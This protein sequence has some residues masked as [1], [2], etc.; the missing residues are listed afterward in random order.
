[1]NK[2]NKSDNKINEV[3]FTSRVE[4]VKKLV[5]YMT[6]VVVDMYKLVR[7]I[8]IFVVAMSILVRYTTVL[9]MTISELLGLINEFINVIQLFI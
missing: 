2:I 3:K 5:R 8:V 1:M 7:D 9:V 6:V 4:H